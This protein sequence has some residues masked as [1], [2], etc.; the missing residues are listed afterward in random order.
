MP[1]LIIGLVGLPGSG[2]GTLAK[3]LQENYGA[4]IFRFSTVLS[5]ILKRLNLKQTRENMIDLS[6]ILRKQFGED[7]LA[8]AIENDA[9]HADSEIVVVD[10]VRRLDDLAALEPLPYFKLIAITAPPELRYTRMMSRGEKSGET[11][12]SWETFQQ[13]EQAPTEITIPAVAARAWKTIDNSGTTEELIGQLDDLMVKL[14]Q[15]V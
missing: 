1:K 12:M 3:L 14:K 15:S 6:E 7:V 5:D 9:I 4:N 2:K 8:Y 13:Q 10:G 11:T